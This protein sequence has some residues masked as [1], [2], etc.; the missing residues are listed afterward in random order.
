MFVKIILLLIIFPLHT[1]MTTTK[2]LKQLPKLS[3]TK[4]QQPTFIS[5]KTV[6]E[7]QDV[8]PKDWRLYLEP[9]KELQSSSSWLSLIVSKIN[10]LLYGQKMTIVSVPGLDEFIGQLK[11]IIYG[12]SFDKIEKLKEKIRLFNPDNFDKKQVILYV[13]ALINSYIDWLKQQGK[14]MEIDRVSNPII[15]LLADFIEYVYLLEN[16]ALEEW[17]QFL[18]THDFLQNLS[19][20]LQLFSEFERYQYKYADENIAHLLGLWPEASYE[21]IKSTYDQRMENYGAKKVMNAVRNGQMTLKEA[22]LRL[23]LAKSITSAW[24]RYYP[25]ISEYER[26]RYEYGQKQL[27][28]QQDAENKSLVERGYNSKYTDIH[29]LLGD[30][31]QD[32]S[33]AQVKDKYFAFM[34]ENHPDKIKD[35]SASEQIKKLDKVQEVTEAMSRYEEERKHKIDTRE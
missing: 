20:R 1:M 7:K 19:Y 30:L 31:S 28:L 33:Y 32:A 12:K 3:S 13:A 15:G 25:T 4:M 18:K 6:L 24:E 8:T 29:A 5:Q 22:N 21:R 34:M 11:E 27:K 23:A 26:N 9:K 10:S 17:Q 14:M 35:L 16:L 2:R